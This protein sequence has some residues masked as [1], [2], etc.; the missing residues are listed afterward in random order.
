MIRPE[1]KSF[2]SRYHWTWDITKDS[3]LA[4]LA[5]VPSTT[6]VGCFKRMAG[7]NYTDIWWPGS[8]QKG[9]VLE[10]MLSTG[11]FQKE[12]ILSKRLLSGA[13]ASEATRLPTTFSS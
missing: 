8:T 7:Q 6:K 3:P 11:N 2:L 10:S 12:A 13:I 4:R 1:L 5:M 9:D